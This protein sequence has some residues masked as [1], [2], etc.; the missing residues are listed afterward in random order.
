MLQWLQASARC[1]TVASAASAAAPAARETLAALD[2]VLQQLPHSLQS[3]LQ[4][5]FLQAAPGTTPE[6]LHAAA[7]HFKTHVTAGDTWVL[8]ECGDW[9]PDAAGGLEGPAR[10][11]LQVIPNATAAAAAAF[12]GLSYSITG[13]RT[14]QPKPFD[15]TAFKLDPQTGLPTG[16]CFR[17]PSGF[18]GMTNRKAQKDYKRSCRVMQDGQS[19]VMLRDL[20]KTLAP[21]AFTSSSRSSSSSSSPRQS[22]SSRSSSSTSYSSSSSSSSSLGSTLSDIDSEDEVTSGLQVRCWPMCTWLPV[23]FTA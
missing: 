7:Q 8:V 4:E 23:K 10:A 5:A 12:S 20:L 14:R 13:I 18:A 17:S 15:V 1:S 3:C 2:P 9:V 6:Q 11:V 21:E 19:T 22:I 16:E